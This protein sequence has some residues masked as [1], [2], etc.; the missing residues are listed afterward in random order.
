MEHSMSIIIIARWFPRP[1]RLDEFFAIVGRLKESLTPE[2]AEA[3][4]V[5]LPAMGR[6]GSV[7]FMERWNDEAVLNSLR[8]S[9]RF[10]EAIRDMS[11]CCHRPLEIEHLRGIDAFESAQPMDAAAYPPGRANPAY[12]PDLGSMT[13]RFV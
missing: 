1:E 4:S 3:F 10:H 6:D 13:P 9:P 2:M 11:A 5:L 7:V 12:Y 8:S